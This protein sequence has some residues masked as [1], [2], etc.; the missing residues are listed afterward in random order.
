MKHIN[1][2]TNF[3]DYNSSAQFILLTAKP[4]LD[5]VITVYSL[6]LYLK[7]DSN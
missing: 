3:K 7:I 5:R 4:Y 2:V 1:G 6:S